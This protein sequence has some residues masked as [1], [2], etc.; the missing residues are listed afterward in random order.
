MGIGWGELLALAILGLL[1]LGPEKLPGFAADAGR[2][3]RQLRRI[4]EDARTEVRE[5]LGPE[6]SQLDLRDVD[7]R[8]FV[9]RHFLA[10]DDASTRRPERPAPRPGERPPYDSEAT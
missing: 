7:P 9:D 1:V 4:A 10:D 8:R 3:I 2:F 5:S 6:L